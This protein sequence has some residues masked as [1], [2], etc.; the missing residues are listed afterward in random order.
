[1]SAVTVRADR[2]ILALQ[3][4]SPVYALQVLL[5]GM[6]DG[7]SV[8]GEEPLVCVASGAGSRLVSFRRG[9]RPVGRRENVV[10]GA[11]ARF[12]RRGILVARFGSLPVN[13]LGERFHDVGMAFGA[14]CRMRFRR[15]PDFVNV[16]MTGRTCVT[17]QHRVNA[18]W[19]GG[20]LIC[21]AGCALHLLDFRRMWKVL[22]GCMAV[23]TAENPMYAG[24]VPRRVNGN[25]CPLFGLHPRLSVTSKTCLVLLLRL[26]LA[27]L[28]SGT[29]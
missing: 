14:F 29:R 15:L 2:S 21:M 13:A 12:T 4:R 20:R 25:V 7:N 24:C 19:D 9:G 22:N 6:H 5:D 27:G 16:A 28:S 11:V 1:M 26:S 8:P 17:P 3:N 23:R 18:F 10:H